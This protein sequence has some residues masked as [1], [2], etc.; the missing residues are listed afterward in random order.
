MLTRNSGGE[1]LVPVGGLGIVTSVLPKPERPQEI[2]SGFGAERRALSF[3][4]HV[5][6]HGLGAGVD[7]ELVVDAADMVAD[8][9]DADV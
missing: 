8:R 7:L 4:S 9:V 2:K 3:L 6:Y 1:Y 5:F